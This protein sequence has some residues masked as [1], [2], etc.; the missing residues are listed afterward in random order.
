MLSSGTMVK[1]LL[2]F[3]CW[4]VVVSASLGDDSITATPGNLFELFKETLTLWSNAGAMREQV[5]ENCPQ[6]YALSDVQFSEKNSNFLGSLET[7][8]KLCRPQNGVELSV[9]CQGAIGIL[10]YLCDV[11][12]DIRQQDDKHTLPTPTKEITNPKQ[13]TNQSAICNSLDDSDQLVTFIDNVSK[14]S[15]PNKQPAKARIRTG[16]MDDCLA[17]CSG[18]DI[19]LCRIILLGMKASIQFAD[20]IESTIE[21]KNPAKTNVDGDDSNSLTEKKG[22]T[23][24]IQASSSKASGKD[25]TTSA[26]KSPTA[27]AVSY[28]SQESPLEDNAEHD[29][30]V[31][32]GNEVDNHEEPVAK[33]AENDQ[34]NPKLDEGEV[35]VNDLPEN[36]DQTADKEEVEN[37]LPAAE[38]EQ[39]EQND[40]EVVPE[41]TAVDADKEASP[42]ETGDQEDQ[43]EDKKAAAEDS[44]KIEAIEEEQESEKDQELQ[45]PETSDEGPKEADKVEDTDNEE[46]DDA[47]VAEDSAPKED[48]PLAADEKAAKS[49]D[50]QTNDDQVEEE[51]ALP[52]AGIPEENE[53]EEALAKNGGIDTEK[54]DKGEDNVEQE[55][56]NE[57]FEENE[58]T[59]AEDD[60]LTADSKDAEDK[61]DTETDP[62]SQL[63]EQEAQN[64][65]DSG[66]QGVDELPVEDSQAQNEDENVEDRISADDEKQDADMEISYDQMGRSP[67]PRIITHKIAFERYTHEPQDT[68]F[69]LYFVICAALTFTGYVI[70]MRWNRIVPLVIRRGGSSVAR[71]GRSTRNYWLLSGRYRKLVGNLEEAM[72]PSAKSSSY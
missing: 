33:S 24:A 23:S 15:N 21:E 42:V 70:I 5:K 27:A 67:S 16:S 68:H 30:S 14:Y 18:T 59:K 61:K 72:S 54:D 35:N 37:A 4:N 22:T 62:E 7:V 2:S 47:Q 17:T 32:T 63:A 46:V 19:H 26:L 10:N 36:A 9:V 20:L 3:V 60:T 43:K 50:T 66:E 64:M 40:D 38:T 69:L 55:K 6:L 11:S 49:D 44:D 1:L 29:A 8:E 71:R 58:D 31:G 25:E 34:E 28:Q 48:T 39:K 12:S 41:D 51:V 52:D 65:P 13:W 57:A 56:E 53:M 45:N